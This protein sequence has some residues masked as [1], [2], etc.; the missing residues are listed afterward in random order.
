MIHYPIDLQQ[1][2]QWLIYRSV[3][4]YTFSIW[5]RYEFLALDLAV[6]EA[7]INA[8][9]DRHESLRTSFA[10]VEGNVMH[11]VHPPAEAVYRLRLIDVSEAPPGADYPAFVESVIAANTPFDFDLEKLPL[12]RVSVFKTIDRYIAVFC[13]AHAFF[14]EPSATLFE[15]EFR[16]I[17]A[18][19]L[20]SGQCRLAPPACQ[21]RDYFRWKLDL[22]GGALAD[23]V[24]RYWK[25]SFFAENTGWLETVRREYAHRDAFGRGPVSGATDSDLAI[26]AKTIPVRTAPRMGKHLVTDER[27]HA[28]INRLVQAEGVT[29]FAYFLSAFGVWL[30]KL[31]DRRN[32]LIT[33]PASHRVDERFDRV[34][35]WF[36]SSAYVNTGVEETIPFREHLRRVFR[37]LP[38]H[39]R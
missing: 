1:K 37:Q 26:L 4:E 31:L 28:R 38:R 36:V 18:S 25:Q 17:Y 22:G 3:E 5:R 11:Q 2:G 27:M 39:I 7:T 9:V 21:L 24:K 13:I 10:V 15:E 32:S 35:G 6:F 16:A 12:F 14:D 8:L 19:L 30:Y 33:L 29:P 20:E 23:E 34:I